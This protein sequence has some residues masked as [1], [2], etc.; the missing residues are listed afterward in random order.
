MP[1][2]TSPSRLSLLIADGAWQDDS[3]AR[4]LPPLLA[5]LGVR[6]VA[7]RS[8]SEA[9]RVVRREPVHIAVVDLSIPIDDPPGRHEAAGG[10]VIE[11][12][13]RMQRP[14]AMVVVRPK[15]PSLREHRQGLMDALAWGAFAVV[16]R[17]VPV[18]QLLHVLHAVV[19]RRF[20]DRWPGEIA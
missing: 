9:D 12:L 13:R 3:F 7:A 10:R 14:P 1:A 20:G 4:Q 18:E 16:D 15:S 8:A 6:C 11:L 5:P 2:P 17:P 19:A